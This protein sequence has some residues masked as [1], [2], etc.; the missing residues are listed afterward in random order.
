[1]VGERKTRGLTQKWREGGE[2]TRVGMSRRREGARHVLT[3]ALSEPLSRRRITIYTRVLLP[4]FYV[5]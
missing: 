5:K 3:D 1:M 2:Q 4:S